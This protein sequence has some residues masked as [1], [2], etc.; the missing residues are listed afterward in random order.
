MSTLALE[1]QRDRRTGMIITILF[2]IGLIVLFLY[3]GL[4]Q[5]DPLPEET[6]GIEIAM[7]DFG[8]S[9]TGSGNIETPNPGDQEASA[10]AVSPSQETPEEVATDDESDVVVTKPEKPKKPKPETTP[11]PKPEPEKP[12][13][14]TIN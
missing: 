9:M 5:P 6:V 14:P 2:H 3:I 1:Q 4:S 7:A 12:K 10:A 11:K 8:T 13:E